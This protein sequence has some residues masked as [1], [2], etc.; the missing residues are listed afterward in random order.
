MRSTQ[1]HSTNFHAVYS[2]QLLK[3]QRGVALWEPAPIAYSSF[4]TTITVEVGDVGYVEDGK[5]K[6]LF[7]G[8]DREVSQRD[9][10]WQLPGNMQS[11]KDRLSQGHRLLLSERRDCDPPGMIFQSE[12]QRNRSFTAGAS[13]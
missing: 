2:R 11:L 13:G 1:V 9:P 12:E 7:S 10:Y 3:H 5:F 8:I 4:D 6:L